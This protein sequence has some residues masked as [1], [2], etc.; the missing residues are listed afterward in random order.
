MWSFR[1]LRDNE[2]VCC[3]PR[4]LS[5]PPGSGRWLALPNCCTELLLI[6]DLMTDDTKFLGNKMISPAPELCSEEEGRWETSPELQPRLLGAAHK[7][8]MG[9]EPPP[10]HVREY[11]KQ[12]KLRV[13]P[14]SWHN[15]LGTSQGQPGA[16]GQP[17]RTTAA[18]ERQRLLKCL[19]N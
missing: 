7:T 19:G 9:L 15:T 18:W 3:C 10:G 1:Q 14:A 5:L 12:A 16:A 2:P 17:W 4:E 6:G 8:L 13:E 11:R